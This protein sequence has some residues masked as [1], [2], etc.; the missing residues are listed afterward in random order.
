MISLSEVSHSS[1]RPGRIALIGGRRRNAIALSLGGKPIYAADVGKIKAR[2]GILIDYAMLTRPFSPTF[3]ASS[4]EGNFIVTSRRRLRL[5]EGYRIHFVEED[6]PDFRLLAS[7]GVELEDARR[8]VQLM[9]EGYRRK[10]QLYNAYR[11]IEPIG[12]HR[13]ELML[14]KLAYANVISYDLDPL[15]EI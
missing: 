11:R 4:L 10:L 7:L 12:Y 13:F 3:D 9:R 1:I 15:V 14:L 2:E 5:P 6:G 8:I